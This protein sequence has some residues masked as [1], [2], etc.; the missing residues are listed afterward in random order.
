MEPTG[1]MQPLMQFGFA[2]LSA[3]LLG[4]LIW[5]VKL[6]IGTITEHNSTLV[7]VTKD[8]T[9]E[10]EKNT[11]AIAASFEKVH[12]VHARQLNVLEKTHQELL[13]RPCILPKE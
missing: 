2:G 6:F 4:V 3:V 9:T 13:K 5:L 1:I 11:A 7:D 12:E 10:I 8:T